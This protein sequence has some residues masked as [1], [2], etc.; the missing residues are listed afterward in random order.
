MK[1]LIPFLFLYIPGQLIF[2]QTYPVSGIVLDKKEEPVPFATIAVL[3]QDQSKPIQGT[4]ADEEGAFKLELTAHTG[5]KLRVS[6]V[7]YGSQTI[8]LDAPPQDTLVVRLASSNTQ[9]DEVVVSGTMSEVSRMESP[10]PVEIYSPAFFQRNPTSNVFE[11]LQNIN[12]IRPQIN[13]NVCNTGDIHINGLEGPY[14]MVL[15]DGMP[16]VSGLST[17]YGLSGIPNA[18]IERIE[19]VKGPASSLYGSEAVGGLINII[20]KSPEKAEKLSLDILTSTWND[21]NLDL[22]FK[23]KPTGKSDLLTGINYFRYTNPIDKNRDNFTDITLQ[24]RISIFQKW[25]NHYK[26][27]KLISLAGRYFYED[28]WGGEMDWSPEF[29]GTDQKY[30]ESIYTSRADIIGYAESPG[31]EHLK[32]QFSFNTHHQN[33]VYGL[34]P[35]SASQRI[36][37]VQLTDELKAKRHHLLTGL[38]MRS[39]FYD[40]NTPATGSADN[41]AISVPQRDLLP[42]VFLQDQ[43]TFTEKNEL[44]AGYRLDYHPR[45]G[46]I[47]TPRVALKHNF[48]SFQ[49]IRLNAGTGFRVVNLFT[50]DHAALTGAREV[51]IKNQLKPERSYNVNLNYMAKVVLGNE[52]FLGIDIS[53]FYTYFT[54]R[55]VPDYESNVQKIIYDNLDGFA[56]SKGVSANVDLNLSTGLILTAGATLMDNTLHTGEE[57]RRPLLTENFSGTWSASY[58]LPFASQWSLDYTGNLY[59]PMNLPLLGELDPRPG[60]SP[61]WSIQN[62]QVSFKGKRTEYYGGIKNLLDFTPPAYSIARS[63]DPFDKNVN[64]DSNGQIIADPQN[65][66]ALSFDPTYVFA[67]NQGRRIFFGVRWFPFR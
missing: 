44:L 64:Y 21:M 30:G 14:T 38:T 36:G 26:K 31:D 6:A 4:T 58:I 46:L 45:H 16:L 11:A 52:S 63:F 57:V 42:G 53:S 51:V 43:W 25:Q 35:F 56:V 22:G 28:R 18:L 7:G 17:V 50:E 41:P 23:F 55:I 1:K 10:V 24:H 27:G 40:D 67:P 20:T 2:S 47:H 60:K 59:S 37:F 13:C 65:P 49:T 62:I 5:L 12:G 34:T 19:A 15:I 8:P 39:V 3:A 33:S 61:W 32:L 48:N 9:F 29:R 54:N 66:Y